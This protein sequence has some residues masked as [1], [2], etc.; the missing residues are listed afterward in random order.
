MLFCK[1]PFENFE[2]DAAYDVFTCCPTYINKYSIGNLKDFS[3]VEI[4]NSEK[5][6]KLRENI[7]NGDYSL[8]NKERC[9]CF[10]NREDLSKE[11]ILRE[12]SPVYHKHPKNIWLYYDE[13]CNARC[14]M[15]RNDF[16]GN[17]PEEVEKLNKIAEEKFLPLL[18]D[19][20]TI[21][22]NGGGELFY[23][24]HSKY[25]V[26]RINELYPDIK[27]EIATNGILCSRKNIFD[28]NLQNRIKT[29]WIS[30]HSSTAETYKKI[31]NVNAFQNVMNN[32][33]ELK[34]MKDENLISNA[35]LVF[36]VSS[37]NFKEIPDFVDIAEKFGM[38][39]S[40]RDYVPYS[41]TEMG[42]NGEKYTVV[43]PEHPLHK[44]LLEV[45]KDKR[46]N[47][48]NHCYFNPLLDKLRKQAQKADND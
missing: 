39:A 22:L 16:H 9:H 14:G 20:E 31:F 13:I 43:N 33:A 2:V 41:H 12:Y 10:K 15:C 7:I 48:I 21:F 5:A 1:R 11:E 24:E 37:L 38:R 34:E 25:L 3:A 28:L 47:N 27:F 40:F 42:Q 26:K 36:V 45:L 44:E 4:W 30:I 17:N 18:K 23:S 6:Q 32:L 8:C 29:L 46:V 19:A 35:E